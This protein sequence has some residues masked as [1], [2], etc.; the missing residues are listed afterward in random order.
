MHDL[1]SPHLSS[2]PLSCGTGYILGS[3][4]D[5]GRLENLDGRD[6]SPLS[7]VDELIEERI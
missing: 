5:S 6:R 2:A 3:V 4:H 7:C 1:L